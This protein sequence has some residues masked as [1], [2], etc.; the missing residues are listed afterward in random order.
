MTVIKKVQEW[1]LTKEF[2]ASTLEDAVTMAAE[3][4]SL[5]W[6]DRANDLEITFY[7]ENASEVVSLE[8]CQETSSG[9]TMIRDVY[10]S[11]AEILETQAKPYM[12]DVW[13]YERLVDDFITMLKK[14]DPNFKENAFKKACGVETEDETFLIN[15]RK[16]L[17]SEAYIDFELEL[18][19]NFNFDKRLTSEVSDKI[20]DMDWEIDWVVTTNI[21]EISGE[22]PGV[23]IVKIHQV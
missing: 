13:D 5:D 22:I 21:S 19:K 16:T 7:L 10:I 15:C 18:P 14:D 3:D 12:E 17:I 11:T 6:S 1:T 2:D 9:I 20:N 23:Y 8:G 4:D